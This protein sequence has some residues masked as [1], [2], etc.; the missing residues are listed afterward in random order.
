MAP[1]LRSAWRPPRD[2]GEFIFFF[3]FFFFFVWANSTDVVFF[4]RLATASSGLLSQAALALGAGGVCGLVI[5]ARCAITDLPQLVAAFHSLVGLAATIT[6]IAA[7][8]SHPAA[9]GAAHLGAA[10]FGVLIGAVTFTGS[11]VAFA[12]LQ[13]LVPSKEV[14]LPGKSAWNTAA[15][16]GALY[17]GK[18]FFNA[19]GLGAVGDASCALYGVAAFGAFL[20]AHATLAVGGGDTPVVITVLNSSSGWALCAEGFVLGSQLLTVVGALIGASGAILSQIMCVAMN[21]S[22]VGVLLGIKGTLKAV[23]YTHLRAHET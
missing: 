4:N 16:L 15:L 14:S 20:G 18:V 23:S 13:G 22:I 7:Y 5:A 2:L 12:K 6:S 3:S 8:M 1:A 9:T 21:R 19:A 11:I 17:C 10:W